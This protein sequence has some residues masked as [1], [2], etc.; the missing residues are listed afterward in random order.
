M[1]A[2]EAVARF[3]GIGGTLWLEG[4]RLRY[5]VP[6]VSPEVVRLLETLR[7]HKPDVAR[8]LREQAPA[9]A[10]HELLAAVVQER[11]CGVAAPARCPPFPPGVRLVSYAPKTP[12]V[13]VARVSIVTDV[14]KFIRVYLRDLSQRLPCPQTRACAPLPEILAKLAEVG[15]ELALE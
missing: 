3:K 12:P 6:D 7:C 4:D 14:D 2:A 15:L 8:L 11:L 10:N 1:E 5:R 13:A 9:S